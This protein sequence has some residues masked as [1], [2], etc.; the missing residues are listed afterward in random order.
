M[1]QIGQANIDAQMVEAEKRMGSMFDPGYN[2]TGLTQYEINKQAETQGAPAVDY[3]PIGPPKPDYILQNEMAQDMQK[4]MPGSTAKYHYDE[5]GN[6]KLAQEPA[7]Q[8]TEKKGLGK[9]WKGLTNEQKA[10]MMLVG[11]DTINASAQKRIENKRQKQLE[12]NIWERQMSTAGRTDKGMYLT[13]SGVPVTPVQQTPVQFTGYNPNT[14][15]KKGAEVDNKIAYLT[16]AEIKAIIQMGGQV[17]F[18]D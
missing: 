9:W 3:G 5:Q 7:K 14:F 10:G 15:A 12:Q 2:P 6:Y 17:E 16:D 8:P 18:L 4:R 11:L 1:S 13:N